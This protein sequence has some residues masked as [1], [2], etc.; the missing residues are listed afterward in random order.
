MRPVKAS[1]SGFTLAEVLITLGIIGIVASMTLPALIADHREKETVARLKKAYSTISNAYILILEEYGSPNGWTISSLENDS[2]DDVAI[3]FSKY[4]RNVRVCTEE[5][6]TYGACFKNDRRHD[7]L[8]NTVDNIAHVSSLIMSDG[9]VIGFS[10]QAAVADIKDNLCSSGNFCFQ[11]EVDINGNKAP[12]R[13]GVDT[14]T[15]Q[16][17]ADRIVPRGGLGSHS[18]YEQCDP[19]STSIARGWWNGSGCTAWVLQRENL[20]Y[21]KCVKGNQKYCS[22][23][24]VFK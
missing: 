11:I 20:D 7:L 15:F 9:T 18:S 6:N 8:N 1:S 12:N 24:Y 16:V 22:Q 3:L 2:W 10:H 17:N 14:F 4:I 21:L 23:K 13:W 19:D 5:Q